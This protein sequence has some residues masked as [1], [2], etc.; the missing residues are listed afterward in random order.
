MQV[1]IQRDKLLQ[2]FQIAASV[3]PTRTPKPILQNVKLTVK[4]GIAVLNATDAEIAIRIEVPEPEITVPGAVLLSVSRFGA[5]LRES[6]DELLT[7]KDN[8]TQ[9]EVQGA[10]SQFRLPSENPD[11]FAEPI[12]FSEEAFFE[13]SSRVLRELIRR[14]IFAI[15]SDNSRYALGGVLFE[16][17]ADKL[18][19]VGTDGKRL[20]AMEAPIK[21]IGGIEPPKQNVIVPARATNLLER[22]LIENDTPVALAPRENNL[23]IRSEKAVISTQLLEGRYPRWRDIL[24]HR[25]IGEDICLTV[26]PLYVAVRQ[27]AI[28][29]D[30]D[31]RAIGFQFDQGSLVLEGS[32][33]QL[34]ESRVELP[35]SYSGPAISVDLDNRFICDFLRVLDPQR[36][37]VLNA[38]DQDSATEFRTDDGYRYI[39]MPMARDRPRHHAEAV[40][41]AN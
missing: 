5:I 11:E 16:F 41:A 13:I 26:G 4:N 19:T 7:I 38:K 22:L 3:V 24:E 33:A 10:R 17:A 1:R 28:I 36:G 23:L 9:L 32:V 35:V 15:D 29:T 21:A 12:S 25:P 39:V 2:A 20:A 6:S 8:G 30:N 18:T 37:I 31:T 14:T 40:A 34:G 27:A